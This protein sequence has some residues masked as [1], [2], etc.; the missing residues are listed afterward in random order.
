MFECFSIRDPDN[1]QPEDLTKPVPLIPNSFTGVIVGAPGSG[2]TS[3]IEDMLYNTK[4]LYK[5]FDLVL[6]VIPYIEAFTIEIPEDRHTSTLS[7]SWI[8]DRIEQEKQ[9]RNIPRVLV[10]LD[11][12]VSSINKDHLNPELIDFFFNRRKMIQGSEVSIL[13]TTQKFTLFPAKYRSCLQWI[14]GF[15][16]NPEDMKIIKQQHIYDCPAHLTSVLSAHFRK[17][18]NFVFIKLDKFGLFLNFDRQI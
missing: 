9:I 11:D 1:N 3:L 18:Y 7:I 15:N 8:K 4:C 10:I 5:K 6:F 2:K 14:V 17:R 16:L 13:C 12:V